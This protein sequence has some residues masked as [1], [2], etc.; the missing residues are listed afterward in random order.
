MDDESVGASG[1][2]SDQ[3]GRGGG[4]NGE[5]RGEEGGTH[6]RDWQPWKTRNTSNWREP[7]GGMR[8]VACV[9]GCCVEWTQ[10]RNSASLAVLS[11]VVRPRQQLKRRL[12]WRG[13]CKAVILVSCARKKRKTHA[14]PARITYRLAVTGRHLQF[15]AITCLVAVGRCP[16]RFKVGFKIWRAYGRH[17]SR[18][19]PGPE[20]VGC[21]SFLPIS[22]RWHA[23][24]FVCIACEPCRCFSFLSSRAR[25]LCSCSHD[26]TTRPGSSTACPHPQSCPPR[27]SFPPA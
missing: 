21:S 23:A 11:L 25:S 19:V 4:D 22:T 12:G 7:R 27:L 5:A 26:A 24:T 9:P 16:S 2:G 15:F 17:Q 8:K 13:R 14:H 1:M 18:P 20:A 6:L 3:L 10:R